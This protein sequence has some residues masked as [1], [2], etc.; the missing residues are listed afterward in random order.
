MAS[1]IDCIWRAVWRP[2]MMPFGVGLNVGTTVAA[3]SAVATASKLVS[4][5]NIKDCQC[6]R[7]IPD[8]RGRAHTYANFLAEWAGE[9]GELRARMR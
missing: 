2:C 7:R 3:D 4:M 9:S 5:A 6:N 8:E 1:D